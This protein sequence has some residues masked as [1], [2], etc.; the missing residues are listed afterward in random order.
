MPRKF[1]STRHSYTARVLSAGA[2]VRFVA[3]HARIT[4]TIGTYDRWIQTD[5]HE[6][7]VAAVDAHPKG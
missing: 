5:R 7:I 4:L 6:H 1:H 2:D 3:D